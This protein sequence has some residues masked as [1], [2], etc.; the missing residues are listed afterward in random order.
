MARTLPVRSLHR[1][2]LGSTNGP[3]LASL[4]TA[5][6]E[7]VGL[8]LSTSALFGGAAGARCLLDGGDGSQ[9]ADAAARG[10]AAGFIV[11]AYV[12]LCAGMYLVL[13]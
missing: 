2:S 10:A 6:L 11:G 5:P 7:V 1:H 4:F 3:L 13:W 8:W 9:I 12:A